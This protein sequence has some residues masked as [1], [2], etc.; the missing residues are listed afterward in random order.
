MTLKPHPSMLSLLCMRLM[1]PSWSS[2]IRYP[3]AQIDQVMTDTWVQV[4][5]RA[6]PAKAGSTGVMPSA[7]MRARI[8]RCSSAR[9][10]AQLCGLV[11]AMRRLHPSQS[12]S[13]AA[14]WH[15]RMTATGAQ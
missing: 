7:R 14:G 15:G 11:P 2:N 10:Q 12:T 4:A 13:C 8:L 6:H 3:S 9:A 1:Q 5:S